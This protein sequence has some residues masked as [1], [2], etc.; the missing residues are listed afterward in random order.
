MSSLASPRITFIGGG[1]MAQALITGLRQRDFAM[2]QITVI[3]PDASK[4]DRLQQTLGVRTA[5]AL[6]AE[7]LQA[8]VIVL[9]VKPQQLKTVAESLA[10]YLQSQLVIS[11]AAGIRTTDL[12]RWL[13]G[14]STLIRTMPNTPAQIQAGVTGVYALASVSEGQRLLA[15]SLLQAAGDVVWLTDEAQLDAVTAISG[16]GPAYVF[17]LIEALTDAGVALGLDKDQALQ[18][19]VA[20]FKGA[21]L[22]AAASET[23]IATLREQVTSKGGT[24]EQGLLSLNQHNIHA[25]MQHAAQQAANRAK[26][27]GDELGGQ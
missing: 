1:N 7:A 25:I 10:P 14:Y 8:D 15:D 22:L 20:T 23:P 19:S 21:S 3:D 26:T 4:Q 27:L 6:S 12:S 17:L 18:L 5:Q 2:Q 11:V 24:T 16:S 9:A 13:N